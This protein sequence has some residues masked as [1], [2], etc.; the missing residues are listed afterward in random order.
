MLIAIR[1]WKEAAETEQTRIRV[2][3]I[4]AINKM[5]AKI[6]VQNSYHHTAEQMKNKIQ[7]RVNVLTQK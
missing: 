2:L 6:C 5:Y 7:R 3:L 1:V 4:A